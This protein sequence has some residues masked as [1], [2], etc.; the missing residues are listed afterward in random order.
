MSKYLPVCLFALGALILAYV[1]NMPGD[2]LILASLG[3]QLIGLSFVVGFYEYRL[4][5]K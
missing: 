4:R 3:G 5:R 1:F 2:Q